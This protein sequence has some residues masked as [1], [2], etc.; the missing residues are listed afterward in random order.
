MAHDQA[1]SQTDRQAQVESASAVPPGSCAARLGRTASAFR[2]LYVKL[3]SAATHLAA[4]KD[5]IPF[6][7]CSTKTVSQNRRLET[8]ASKPVESPKSVSGDW[9]LTCEIARNRAIFWVSEESK[10]EIGLGGW[11]GRIRTSASLWTCWTTQGR[12]P[13]AHAEARKSAAMVQRRFPI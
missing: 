4:R 5:S 1:K 8:A 7:T 2:I 9:L 6:E 12:C 11:G 3:K 13:H 10:W